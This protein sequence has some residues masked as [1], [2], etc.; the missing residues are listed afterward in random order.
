M[1][2]SDYF[3]TDTT[4]QWKLAKQLGVNHGVI[5]LPENPEFDIT[6]R[7]HMKEVADKFKALGIQPLVVE[8]MPNSVH[9]HIKR[10]DDKRDESIEKVLK[11]IPLLAENGYRDIC[12]NFMAEIG[13]CRTSSTIQER[14]GALVTGFDV[15]DL[16]VD[17]SLHITEE[18]LWANL[19]YFLKAVIPTCE[20]YGVRIALHPDDPP[21]RKM[22]GVSRILVSKEN[23]QRAIDLVPSDCL[24]ITM[25]QANFVT[26]GEDIYDCIRHFGNQKKIFLVH[27]RDVVGNVECF[28][29]TF[30]ATGQTDMVKALQCYKEVGF[31]GSI[32][33][34]H[35]PTMAGEG[36]GRPGYET[37]G[38]RYAVGYLRGIA[39]AIG[40][41]LR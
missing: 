10:A 24:G 34:D 16:K 5:R 18:E 23:F 25:C 1:L 4:L 9:D 2:L 40:Y 8:P 33:I 22:G 38:R 32:R 26:M 29:E 7:A 12:T 3:Y 21:L 41:P 15:K 27:F 36:N 11:M 17:P 37:M 14:G 20:Q 6:N 28:H 31:D 35:V 19:E 13:W 30:H 39:E